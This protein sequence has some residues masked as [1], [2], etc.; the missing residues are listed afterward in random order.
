MNMRA[1]WPIHAGAFVALFAASRGPGPPLPRVAPERHP[2]CPSSDMSG[3]EPRLSRTRAVAQGLGFDSAFSPKEPRSDPS[4]GEAPLTA[5][6]YRGLLEGVAVSAGLGARHRVTPGNA[7]ASPHFSYSAAL[8]ESEKAP[9]GRWTWPMAPKPP[10]G[11]TR[12]HG[13]ADL[14]QFSRWGRGT[15]RRRRAAGRPAVPRWSLLGGNPSVRRDPYLGVADTVRSP[16]G[17]VP[18]PREGGRQGTARGPA[19]R[20]ADRRSAFPGRRH[21]LDGGVP[22]RLGLAPQRAGSPCSLSDTPSGRSGPSLHV[23][24]SSSSTGCGSLGCTSGREYEKSGLASHSFKRPPTTS[25]SA[26]TA[27][28]SCESPAGSGPT[29]RGWPR[30]HRPPPA[31]GESGP[32]AAVR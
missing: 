4:T 5:E 18:A 30:P 32:K 27:S 3:R 2:G 25:A 14:R 26:A 10:D 6:Q 31:E 24:P 22:V 9:R 1:L 23:Q 12:R 8:A 7:S 29:L 16:A 17:S 28:P 11:A 21:H 19:G 13:N 20:C 15:A